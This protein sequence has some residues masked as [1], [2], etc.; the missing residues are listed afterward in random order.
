MKILFVTPEIPSSSGGGAQRMLFM[1]KYLSNLGAEIHLLSLAAQ[2]SPLAEI[3]N[4]CKDLHLVERKERFRDKAKNLIFF[5]AY[6]FFPKFESAVREFNLSD[7]DLIHVQ[8]FQM[9]EY[10]RKVKKVPVV[11]DLWACGL[12]GSWYEFFYEK[13]FS[14]KLVKLSRIPRFYLSDIR[15]YRSF[16]YFFVVSKEAKEYILKRYPEKKVYIV[17]TGIESEKTSQTRVELEKKKHNLVFS[18]DMGFFQNID[19][20]GYFAKRIFPLIK[21]KIK[22]AKFFIVG[23]NPAKKVIKLAKKDADI[24]VTGFVKDIS[25]YLRNASVFVAPIRTGSGIRTKILEAM[26]SSLPLVTSKRATEGI[27]A[28]N[29][30]NLLM[31]RTPLEFAHHVV[32]LL[33]HPQKQVK[34]G[35]A[36]KKLIQEKYQWETISKD[37]MAFYHDILKDFHSR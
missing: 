22:D 10:F 23:K 26:A 7:F 27:E 24:V 16:K 9:A 36:G 29:G 11:I 14:R 18:G 8:K 34:I 6:T 5:R 35:E 3:R 19:T 17:P 30:K 32:D 12:S 1:M 4:W 28:E 13:N 21:K 15:Y 20:V 25:V 37:I 31:A 33:N 2:N